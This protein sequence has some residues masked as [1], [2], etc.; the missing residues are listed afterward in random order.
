MKKLILV[1]FIS[2]FVLELRGQYVK[3]YYRE[4]EKVTKERTVKRNRYFLEALKRNVLVVLEEEDPKKIK[5][6]QKSEMKL[7]EYRRLIDL[8][9]RLLMD[10]IPRFWKQNNATIEFKKNS[11]CIALRQ[12]GSKEYF[13]IEFASMKDKDFFLPALS[14]TDPLIKRKELLTKT[15]NFGKFEACLIEKFGKSSFYEFTTITSVP[16]E[17][18]YIISIQMMNNFFL[19]KFYEPTISKS[20]YESFS[21]ERHTNLQNKT[22][23]IDSAQVAFSPGFNAKDLKENYPY[24]YKMAGA[25]EI[26]KEVKAQNGT[27]AYLLINPNLTITGKDNSYNNTAGGGMSEVV[28]ET[29]TSYTHYIIDCAG[30][31]PLFLAKNQPRLLEKTSWKLNTT[32][33]LKLYN[34][35]IVK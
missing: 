22:L 32:Y 10:L 35:K 5:E 25:T 12:A 6:L 34:F 24:N 15:G 17:L 33:I 3:P 4:D 11:E 31:E 26:L 1:F 30:S 16:N 23:L 28:K 21:M 29:T 13:T 20:G 8:N 7:A 14:E 9:N 27:Y 18:D 19:S 2:F